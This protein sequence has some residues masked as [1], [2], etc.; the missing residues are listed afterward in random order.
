MTKLE[1]DLQLTNSESGY[2]DE[3]IAK[4]LMSLHGEALATWAGF[5]HGNDATQINGTLARQLGMLGVAM[6]LFG[7]TKNSDENMQRDA[8]NQLLNNYAL[9]NKYSFHAK[10]RESKPCNG[11]PINFLIEKVPF[12]SLFAKKD[13]PSWSVS[14]KITL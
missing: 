6:Q 1:G 10:E 11:A 9:Q 2:S 12:P 4:L 5:T 3:A 14:S 7:S 13:N 8:I